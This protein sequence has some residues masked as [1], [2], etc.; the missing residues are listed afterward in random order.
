[1]SGF[2]SPGLSFSTAV[3]KQSK[4]S[5]KK[6]KPNPLPYSVALQMANNGSSKK[7]SSSSSQQSI[8]ASELE[9]RMKRFKAEL[10]DTGKRV[11]KL[12]DYV[13]SKK[14]KKDKTSKKEK[15]NDGLNEPLDDLLKDFP[16]GFLSEGG[17]KWITASWEPRA[18]NVVRSV[19]VF[20][21]SKQSQQL[22]PL[23]WCAIVIDNF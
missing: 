5:R 23:R 3:A 2:D 7:G 10:D 9:G 18:F 1:M 6:T 12:D 21:W 15:K 16:E 19:N 20:V 13:K 14:K 8:S 22:Q 11:K 4:A 17:H